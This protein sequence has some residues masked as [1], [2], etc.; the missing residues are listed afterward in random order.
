MSIKSKAANSIKLS[1]FG[2]LAWVISFCLHSDFNSFEIETINEEGELE[3]VPDFKVI[4]DCPKVKLDVSDDGIYVKGL[5]GLAF[6]T[7][8]RYVIINYG[9]LG[10]RR[11]LRNF[12][13]L[14]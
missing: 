3:I 7:N 12:K 6:E 2:G 4:Y 10:R 13:C 9:G 11:G 14:D 1:I 5:K 8:D